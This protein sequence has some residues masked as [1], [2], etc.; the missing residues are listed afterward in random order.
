MLIRIKQPTGVMPTINPTEL[1]GNAAQVANNCVFWSNDVAPLAGFGAAAA[2]LDKPGTILSLYRFG[3]DVS[4]DA[5][6]WFHWTTDV[7]VARGMVFGDT[8]EKTYFTGDGAYPKYTDNTV[9]LSGTQY[10]SVSYRLGVPVPTAAPTLSSITGSVSGTASAISIVYTYVDDNGWEGAPSPALAVNEIYQ[11]QTVN[12]SGFEGVVAGYRMSSASYCRVYVSD[13]NGAFRYVG[14][15]STLG[16][17]ATFSFVYNADTVTSGDLISTAFDPPPATLKGLAGLHNGMMAGFTGIDVYICEPYKPWAWSTDYVITAEHPVVALSSY[18]QTL[19]ILTKGLPVVAP[20]S[21]PSSFTPLPLKGFRQAC[22]SKRSVVQIAGGVMYACPDGMA[23]ISAAGTQVVTSVGFARAE[24]QALKPESIVGFRA[25]DRYVG[26]FDTGTKK[27]AF[28]LDMGSPKQPFCFIDVHATAGYNDLLNDGLYLVQTGT[29]T[30]KRLFGGAPLR[31]TW[32]SKKFKLAAPACLSWG[33][34][35]SSSPVG[36]TF[37]VYGDGELVD[38]VE[39]EDDRPFR[40]STQDRHRIYELEIAG[41][42]AATEIAIAST[43]AELT[44][45]A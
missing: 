8:T 9:A 19:V 22:V 34:V 28:L 29:N 35:L 17:G 24:W 4:G 6:Y 2:S 16:I 15:T 3:Q 37:R 30:V 5:N 32:R 36:L 39:I 40:L 20:G 43:A 27:G 38:E 25:E 7:D 1:P 10:P 26:F 21:D 23:F 42:T 14:R 41:T 11:G 13:T 45:D 44:A 33:R 31:Y 12:L 18:D